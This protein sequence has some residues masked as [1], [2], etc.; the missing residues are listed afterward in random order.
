MEV[1]KQLIEDTEAK[2]VFDLK[3]SLSLLNNSIDKKAEE[4]RETYKLDGFR[5]GKVP[6][7]E[8]KKREK[9]NLFYN[10][11]EK[12]IN[13]TVSNIIKDNN[14]KL[15]SQ[16]AVDIKKF[17][18]D[19]DV[20]VVVTIELMPKVA[21]I[22]LKK[23]NADYYKVNV[24]D[25]DVNKSIDKLLSYYSKWNKKDGQ[26]QNGDMVK[27]NFVGYVD[28]NE[29]SGNRGEEFNLQLGSGTFIKGFEEQLINSKAGDKVKVKTR[30]PDM[31][32]ATHLAGKDVEFD[33]EVLEVSSAAKVD[34]TDEF[35]K[36]NF[37]VETVEA[38]KEQIKKE[39]EKDYEMRSRE[40]IRSGLVDKLNAMVNFK[41]PENA[42]KTRMELIKKYKQEE[43][44]SIDLLEDNI[45]AEAER[46][47]KC[48]Y[49]IESIAEKNN[50][51]VSDSDITEAIMRDAQRMVGNEQMVIDYYKNNSSAVDSLS[52]RLMEDKV[53][54]YIIDNI[55]K[56][57]ISV[58]TDEF[59][60]M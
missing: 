22:D 42:L 53:M 15:A 37:A 1:E 33:V 36:K 54:N 25:A 18:V 40:M 44:G 7:E 30:F 29:F 52:A 28:G 45:K 3:I 49:I 58:S 41:L 6:V 13:D 38:F 39:L 47:L 2:K 59:N 10:T 32:H 24:T 57:E 56:K 35:V 51:A 27:I 50:I 16:A 11:A 12:L 31:Y 20:E 14:Y 19:N 26:A 55:N 8:I 21:D 43:K 60:N 17:E 48:G 5:V 23:I 46:T 4:L 34:L 9:V